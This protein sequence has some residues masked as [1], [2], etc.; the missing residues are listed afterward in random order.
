[1]AC[2]VREMARVGAIILGAGLSTRMGSPKQLLRLGDE[3]M[4]ERV[5]DVAMRS[6][7]NPIVLV[8][9]A[10]AP[11]IQEK[12]GK[13]GVRVVINEQYILGIATS[14]KK[15][16][17][18]IMDEVDALLIMLGDQ[19]FL[20]PAF[21]D[22]LIESYENSGKQLVVP[23]YKGE[24]RNPVLFDKSL[25]H[26]L[27][28]LEGDEGAKKVVERNMDKCATV[29]TEDESLFVDIDTPDQLV[30]AIRSQRT[31]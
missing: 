28:G 24:Q 27:L 15:G 1:M 3:T 23:I 5:V 6:R 4:L 13:E 18:F 9:G 16:L 12:M 29:E 25:F 17:Q 26:E 14:V 19:P 11:L 10:N 2:R 7:A 22:K 20:T 8:V 21:L 30:R 31:T